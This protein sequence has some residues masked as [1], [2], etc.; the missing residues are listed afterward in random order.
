MWIYKHKLFHRDRP[1]DLHM[2]RRRTC[3]GVDGRKQ[4][5]SRFSAQKL[6]K[7]D[8]TKVTQSS[9]DETTSLEDTSGDES[10]AVIAS[11]LPKKKRVIGLESPASPAKRTRRLWHASEPVSVPDDNVFVDT[12][13]LTD[14]SPS[15]KDVFEPEM[16][17]VKADAEADDDS[18]ANKKN[19]RLEMIEQAMIVSEVATKLEEYA[20]K[21]MKGRGGSR[22]RRGVVGVVTPPWGSYQNFTAS[23]RGLITYDDEY[24]DDDEYEGETTPGLVVDTDVSLNGQSSGVTKVEAEL[25]EPPVRD[26]GVVKRVSDEIRRRA[27]FNFYHAEMIHACAN[28][29]EFFMSTAP[30]E[31]VDVCCNKILQL[32]SSSTKLA[33]DFHM[34]RAALHPGTA[35]DVGPSSRPRFDH[36]HALALRRMLEGGAGRLDALREFK[37]FAVNLIYK[38]LGK[39]GTFD[40]QE[41]FADRDHVHLLRTAESWSKSVG[42]SA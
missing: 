17:L 6:S 34:Y 27:S 12:S 29:A 25:R 23:S 1:E 8:E 36:H 41:P 14:P 42:S 19:E 40:F 21:A 26:H 32:L 3:P 7:F 35:G 2:V 30:N 4:R 16:T 5:F 28:L 22:T 18:S 39:N 10:E 38:L 24:D 20:R 9:D 15:P 37:I 31:E 33:A 13:I 11:S